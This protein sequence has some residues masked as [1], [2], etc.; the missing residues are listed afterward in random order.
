MTIAKRV[1]VADDDPAMVELLQVAILFL[2]IG[3]F[4]VFVK[5]QYERLSDAIANRDDGK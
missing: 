3:G 2:L 1:L 5:K 4:M